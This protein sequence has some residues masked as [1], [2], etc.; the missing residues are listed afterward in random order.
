MKNKKNKKYTLKQAIEELQSLA[1]SEV[2]DIVEELNL[3]KGVKDT[4]DIIDQK[5]A[6]LFKKTRAQQSFMWLQDKLDELEGGR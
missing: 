6:K 4:E 1:A 2:L 5:K 3:F